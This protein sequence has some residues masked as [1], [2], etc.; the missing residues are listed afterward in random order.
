MQKHRVTSK[1]FRNKVFD[2]WRPWKESLRC[3]REQPRCCP[4]A[5]LGALCN[6][7]IL[8]LS[9]HQIAIVAGSE[10]IYSPR[11]SPDGRYIAAMPVEATSLKI[12]D[13]Q[14][15]KWSELIRKDTLGT[16]AFPSWSRDGK[17]IYFLRIAANAD[18]G[19]FRVRAGGGDPERV[20]SLKNIDLGGFW[21]WTGLDPGDAPL[22]MRDTGSNDI[23]SLTLEQK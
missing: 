11:W 8:D 22:V 23:Y 18:K 1:P 17:S 15:Q 3:L 10:G 21:S 12:F 5:D 16:L 19:I 4:A 6:L 20:V 2:L 14:S 7:R 13:L 9:T